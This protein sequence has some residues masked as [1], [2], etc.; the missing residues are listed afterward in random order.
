MSREQV[1]H[2]RTSGVVE[3]GERFVEQPQRRVAE[4]EPRQRSATLL[5]GR[6]LLTR[7]EFVTGES[8]AVE[9]R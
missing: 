9:Q 4:A 3:R 6:Q 5:T 2:E 1:A 8:D 7:R